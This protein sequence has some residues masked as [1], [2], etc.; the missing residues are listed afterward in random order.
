VL[1][2]AVVSR[3]AG[4]RFDL[5]SER[6]APPADLNEVLDSARWPWEQ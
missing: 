5:C 2:E 1:A 6:G 4:L 3:S